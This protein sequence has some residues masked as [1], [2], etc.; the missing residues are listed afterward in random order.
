M[1]DTIT[2]RYSA[3]N[4]SLLVGRQ[5]RCFGVSDPDYNGLIGTV[6]SV[7]SVYGRAEFKS[8]QKPDDSV[9]LIF[10]T[11]E[12]VSDGQTP[13]EAVGAMLT[14]NAVS[15]VYAR[16]EELQGQVA[17]LTRQLERAN[18]RVNEYANRAGMWERDFNRSW[19]AVN[20]E[21]VERDWCEEYERV[22]QRVQQRLEI[23]VIPE[24]RK[25]LIER[26]VRIEGTVYRHITVWV[27]D[28]E[29]ATDPD[30]WYESDDYDDG[31]TEDFVT[32]QLTSECENNG[33]D[34]TSIR[35]R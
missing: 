18:E 23:G 19:E 21:A 32:E 2:N 3:A 17:E 13:G 22:Q 6:T 4:N 34:D 33:W 28:G 12:E 31:C 26:H 24:R 10:E 7:G 16:N 35:L 29:D 5:V 14:E 15:Q 30:N 11:Y 27:P 20:T 1:S 25:P 9:S 8:L